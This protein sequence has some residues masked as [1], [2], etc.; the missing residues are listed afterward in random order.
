MRKRLLF[1]SLLLVAGIAIFIYLYKQGY[2]FKNNLGGNGITE[3]VI[4][5]DI[6]YP[7]LDP[8]SMIAS[9]MPGKA[10]LRFKDNNTSNDMSGMMGMINI[11]YIANLKKKQVEQR[12][13]LINKKYASEVSAAELKKFNDSYISSIE[14]GTRFIKIAG[15]KCR[16][17]IVKLTDGKEAKV[18]FTNDIGIDSANW[19]NPYCQIT[20]VLMDFDIER[21]GI[22][23][24]WKA[25]SVQAQ[26][27]N[28]NYFNIPADTTQYKKI[29][30]TELEKI[31]EDLNPNSN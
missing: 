18:Y 28:D 14:E 4:E 20:G 10:F 1:I 27:I 22:T 24:H 3:G 12:L 30:F 8:N 13:T 16:E 2:V 29:V 11:T 17:A 15:Y 26:S 25:K 23:M 5:Y 19:A 9:G 6:T 21:Y 31:L 7:F